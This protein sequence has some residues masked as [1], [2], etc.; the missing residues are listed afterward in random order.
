MEAATARGVVVMNTPESGCVTTA[1]LAIAHLFALARK[2]PQAD[3]VMKEG[4]WDKSA[5]MGAEVTGKTLGVAGLGR[6]GRVVAD[7]ALGLKM[8]VLAYDPYVTQEA[9]PPGVV[10]VGFDRLLAESDFV[11]VHV[12]LLESTRGL[13]DEKAFAKMKPGA[14]L[15]HCA[16]GGIVKEAA[17]VEALRSGRLSAAA[18]DV[19]EEEPPPADHPL[20]SMPQVV[21]SPHLGAS[22]EEAK[23]AVGIDLARQIVALL[24]HGVVVNGVNV[25]H[26]APQD[27]E[28]LAPFLSLAER[29]ASLLMQLFGGGVAPKSIRLDAQGEIGERSRRPLMVAAL[30]G[31]LRHVARSLVTPV[32]AERL[33]KELGVPFSAEKSTLKKDFVNLLSVSIETADGARHTASGTLIGKRHVRMVQ[34]DEFLLDAIPEGRLLVSFHDDRPG[35]IGTIGTALGEAGVNISRLQ[36]GTPQGGGRAI[37]VLNIDAAAPER[38]LERLRATPGIKRLLTVE[39]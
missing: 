39:L 9:A 27:A 19:F 38:A 13:F 26:V 12:P 6:I 10:V 7:R 18:L 30:I 25:P 24:R 35:M 28:F 37:G 14:R 17:L 1:E 15:V 20:R 29:L 22:T 8:R 5:L 21:L 16:R 34:L 11:T 2:I 31:A 36:L 4:R 23:R 33:A 32:N 3:R